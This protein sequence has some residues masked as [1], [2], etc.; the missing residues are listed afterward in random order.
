MSNLSCDLR[1]KSILAL[2]NLSSFLETLSAVD[3]NI[4]K[5]A[6]KIF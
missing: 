5:E 1:Q 6:T 3:T 2:K 4:K